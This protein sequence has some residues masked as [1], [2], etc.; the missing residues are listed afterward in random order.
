MRDAFVA[1]LTRLARRDPRLTLVVGDLGYGVIDDFAN[2]MPEQFVNAGVAEQNMI[3]I[4]AGLAASGRRVFVYSIANFAT[5]RC[6]EQIRNDLCY[7]QQDVSIVSVGAGVAYG[8]HGYTHHAVEDISALRSLP[9][10]RILSPADPTEAAAAAAYCSMSRGPN[11]VRLGKNGEV[12]LHTADA[13]LDLSQPL[14]LRQGSDVNILATGSIVEACLTAAE[15]LSQSHD[16]E[17]S[18]YSCPLVR[19]LDPTWLQDLDDRVPL[20]TVEEHFREG[21]FGSL[22]LEMSNDLRTGHAITRAGLN[23]S[24]FSLLGS[25]GYLRSQS[26]LDID[27]I[28]KAVLSASAG[29]GRGINL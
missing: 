11:Y 24:N 15:L 18:V 6:L 10:L 29:V 2:E 16:I 20:V 17:C 13:T 5:L 19:P 14:P 26:N 22:V 25:Q 27:G 1:E 9:G 8:T 7:H 3:G 21:G 23:S 12:R 28:A 4:A